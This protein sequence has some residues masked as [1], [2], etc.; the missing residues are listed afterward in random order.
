MGSYPDT[1]IDP[2]FLSCSTCLSVPSLLLSF[3]LFVCLFFVCLG[4]Y[5]CFS[6]YLFLFFSPLTIF[7]YFFF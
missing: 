2:L 5:I 1:D 4:C 6:L 3:I 7:S